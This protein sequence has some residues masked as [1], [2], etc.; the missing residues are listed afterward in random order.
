[1]F[2]RSCIFHITFPP[3]K[4][5]LSK[6]SAKEST[7][8]RNVTYVS[9]LF[10]SFNF[11]A[12][13]APDWRFQMS[14]RSKKSWKMIFYLRSLLFSTVI[15]KEKFLF[16]SLLQTK[17]RYISQE[18]KNSIFLFRKGNW[19]D[20]NEERIFVLF[21]WKFCQCLICNSN[22]FKRMQLSWVSSQSQCF[23]K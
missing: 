17:D 19:E 11:I 10:D 6:A 5:S 2:C 13:S 12:Y 22:F 15:G 7:Y 14:D 23:L 1:M 8:M 9:P 21:R 18:K 3:S 16:L 20:R 4:L